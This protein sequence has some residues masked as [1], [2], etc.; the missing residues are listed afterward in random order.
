MSFIPDAIEV[1]ARSWIVGLI[2]AE[3]APT[4]IIH[5][6][7]DKSRPDSPFVS[8][9]ILDDAE[10]GQPSEIMRVTDQLLEQDRIITLR[11]TAYGLR[12]RSILD[13]VAK[14]HGFSS[15][16]LEALALGFGVISVGAP[17]RIPTVLSQKTEE[18]W[19]LEARLHYIATETRDET[20]LER[21]TVSTTI[22]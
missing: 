22:T 4:R 6:L 8:V 20:A 12:A 7:Q 15:A 11:V 9:L 10:V 16:R 13:R 5:E 17:R 14:R 1:A 19:V 2:G 3:L 21:P 18:R